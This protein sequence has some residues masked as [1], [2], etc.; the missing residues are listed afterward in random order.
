MQVRCSGRCMKHSK[1]CH[2]WRTD[3]LTR[4]GL[5][6]G[7]SPGGSHFELL[8]ANVTCFPY[9]QDFIRAFHLNCQTEP[10]RASGVIPAGPPVL[11][12]GIRG[13]S[14]EEK[15]PA[16][17]PVHGRPPSPPPHGHAG[18]L[19]LRPR[20]TFEGP[21]TRRFST[22]SPARAEQRPELQE[23]RC[24]QAEQRSPA[25]ACLKRAVF[26][27][28]S[29]S[30]GTLPLMRTVPYAQTMG[31]KVKEQGCVDRAARREG[32]MEWGRGRP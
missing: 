27:S 26:A 17:L 9:K 20:G 14:L 22:Q 5:A 29:S 12:G 1:V 10:E 2:A 7:D 19:T 11:W 24:T 31:E 23:K 21:M 15:E 25:L 6:L 32:G 4:G 30:T 3:R 13:L 16:L 18:T 28:I 8:P